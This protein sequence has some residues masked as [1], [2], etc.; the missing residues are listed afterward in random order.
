MARSLRNRVRVDLSVFQYQIL[1]FFFFF[2]R[3]FKTG[4]LCVALAILE[5]ALIDQV[6]LRLIEICLLLPPVCWD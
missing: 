1:S 4:F 5:L 3:F 2:S 6:G